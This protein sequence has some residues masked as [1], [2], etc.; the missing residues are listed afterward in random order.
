[1]KPWLIQQIQQE[2][3]EAFGSGGGALIEMQQRDRL[4]NVV[5]ASNL[6]LEVCVSALAHAPRNQQGRPGTISTLMASGSK[7]STI[8]AQRPLFY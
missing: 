5:N 2:A 8:P 3:S 7:N 1:L 4:Y 6:M